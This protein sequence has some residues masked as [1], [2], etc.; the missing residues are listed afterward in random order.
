MNFRRS[1]AAVLAVSVLVP[2]FCSCKGSRTLSEEVI[3]KEDDLWYDSV[4]FEVDIPGDLH[5]N[6]SDDCLNISYKDGK[7]YAPFIVDWEDDDGRYVE[8][9]LN[10]Y[11]MEGNCDSKIIDYPEDNPDM[12]LDTMFLMPNEDGKTATAVIWRGLTSVVDFTYYFS[13][14]D[15]ETGKAGEFHKIEE[16]S[17]DGVFLS[18][19]LA[20][21]NYFCFRCGDEVGNP[22]LIF[23]EGDRFCSRIDVKDMIGGEIAFGIDAI[24][25]KEGTDSVYVSFLS[26]T[27]K[28]QMLIDP[29]TGAVLE[30]QK[31]TMEDI[32][33]RSSG[34]DTTDMSALN[35]TNEGE[36]MCC[37]HI[38]NIYSYNGNDDSLELAI[39]CNQYSPYLY[40]YSDESSI[41]DISILSHTDDHAILSFIAYGDMLGYEHYQ[42]ITVL[43]KIPN[44]HVGKKVIDLTFREDCSDYMS[45]AIYNFNKTDNEYLI[46]IWKDEEDL[47]IISAGSLYTRYSEDSSEIMINELNKEKEDIA[48]YEQKL[49]EDLKGTDVP[50]IILDLQNTRAYNNGCLEDLSDYL[51]A[52]VKEMLF[53]NVIEATKYD[54]RS[55]FLPVTISINGIVCPE[56]Q[57]KEGNNG[58]T[59]DDYSAFVHGPSNGIEPFAEYYN[60]RERTTFLLACTD[61]YSM[62]TDDKVDFGTE[63]FRAA[64]EYARNDFITTY[65][66]EILSDLD[67]LD[68]PAP[69]ARY[70]NI[71]SYNDF[72]AAYAKVTEPYIIA[73]APSVDAKGP[74]F[75]VTESISVAAASEVKDGAK[76]FLNYLFR[77][78]F[79]DGE[80]FTSIPINKDVLAYDLPLLNQLCLKYYSLLVS[81][82]HYVSEITEVG[83]RVTT[84]LMIEQFMKSLSGLS[85]YSHEDPE[86]TL[87]LIEETDQYFNGDKPLD[88]VIVVIN[89]KAQKIINER[90]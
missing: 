83:Y 56:D 41:E 35:R 32:R 62:I 50:D 76:R 69:I 34:I 81:H 10:I 73:G 40:D 12:W 3:V 90:N 51:E 43:K 17:R 22:I 71:S 6:Q 16:V 53:E 68:L 7:I 45:S 59:F 13:T 14:V 80:I 28:I 54:D 87:M 61:I 77:G 78:G 74:S 86:L 82:Y 84:D 18:E 15:L 33:N 66:G 21:G 67:Y 52:D 46:R 29:E 44:P 72:I 1:L 70:T 4:R 8:T 39:D 49:I 24:Y 19:V 48:S 25:P 36:L 79:K 57:L 47:S 63:Q 85:Y 42:Y 20:V 5:P 89:D 75:D 58:F 30:N 60:S 2:V 65:T 9:R 31:E 88:E 38:G 37:D 27:G 11:D 23:F 55:Y 26:E 64:A